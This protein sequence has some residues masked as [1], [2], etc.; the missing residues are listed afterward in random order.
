[1]KAN[2]GNLDHVA[3]IVLGP[4]LLSLTVMGPRTWFGLPGLIPLATATMG[5]LPAVHGA[6]VLDVPH[7]VTDIIAAAATMDRA[8]RVRHVR[9]HETLGDCTRTA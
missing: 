7:E 3:R 4:G 5:V 1:M 2:V 9:V 6:R 8:R